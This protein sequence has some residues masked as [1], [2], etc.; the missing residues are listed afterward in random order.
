MTTLTY[1]VTAT[2]NIS[3][4]IAAQSDKDV[5]EAQLKA[6]LERNILAQNIG[7]GDSA[8]RVTAIEEVEA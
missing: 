7:V 3:A 5:A 1:T 4:A 6:T 8:I 2:L